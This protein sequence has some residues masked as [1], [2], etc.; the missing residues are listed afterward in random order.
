MKPAALFFV[1]ES[2][3][4]Q[5]NNTI[6]LSGSQCR[7]LPRNIHSPINRE[8]QPIENYSSSWRKSISCSRLSKN[9]MQSKYVAVQCICTI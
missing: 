8:Y 5:N 4:I 2:N 3:E 6:F 1:Y 9:D 7:L